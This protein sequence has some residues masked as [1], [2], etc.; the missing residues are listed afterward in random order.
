MSKSSA[1][2]CLIIA[3]DINITNLSLDNREMASYV[4]ITPIEH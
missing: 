3:L 1:K 2:Q 4:K